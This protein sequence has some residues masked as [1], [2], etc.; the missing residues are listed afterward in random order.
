MRGNNSLSGQNI[1]IDTY[2][3][4]VS[5]AIANAETG[6]QPNPNIRVL[7]AP[8]GGSSAYGK[9]QVTG[10]KWSMPWNIVQG[11]DKDYY[12]RILKDKY[13][14]TEDTF[15]YY[16]KYID[17]ARNRL[18]KYGGK[19]MVPGM[20]HLDYGGKGEL[21]NTAK[22]RQQY[23]DAFLP[24]IKYEMD[25]AGGDPWQFITNWRGG[26]GGVNF[27]GDIDKYKQ[28]RNLNMGV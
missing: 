28:L 3:D 2:W 22:D 7:D 25:R 26:S 11:P 27:G 23:H 20:E 21:L 8:P 18:L 15:K 9:F 17:H 16:E 6:T 24:M 13:G 1:V 10:G 14:A 19:D 4:Q 12:Q 5:K